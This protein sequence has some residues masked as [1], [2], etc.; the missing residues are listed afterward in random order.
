MNSSAIDALKTPRSR[1]AFLTAGALGGATAL[2]AGC[3]LASAGVPQKRTGSLYLT[4]A[5]PAMLGTDDLPAYIPAYPRVPANATVR[6]EIANFDDA[7]PL[8][9]A[10]TQF[11]K[12]QGTVGGTVSI[13]PLDP[14]NP[15]SSAAPQ[16]TSEVDPQNGVSH[17]FTIA[18][19]GINVPVAPKARTI[20]TLETGAPGT[21]VWRCNDP[22][23]SGPSGWGGAM[24]TD[25]YMVGKLTIE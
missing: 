2:L 20:F 6:V 14:K 4:I 1:R 3:G 5:T 9:G 19:L 24:S 8:T 23:G 21:F 10:L 7:T 25:G 18:K 15:N 11:A 22:C 16:V 13:E 12:V 17:T